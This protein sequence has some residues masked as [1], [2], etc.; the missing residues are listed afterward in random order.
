MRLWYCGTSKDITDEAEKLNAIDNGGN[1]SLLMSPNGGAFAYTNLD[2][3]G[4]RFYG[5]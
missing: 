4:L 3:E 1:I 2:R 5:L